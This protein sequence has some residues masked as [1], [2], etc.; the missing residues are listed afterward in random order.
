MLPSDVAMNTILIFGFRFI[1]P[2]S[3]QIV[4]FFST[5][6]LLSS[7]AI[8]NRYGVTTECINLLSPSIDSPLTRA[9]TSVWYTDLH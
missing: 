2:K 8:S 5:K 6:S 3:V 4:F 9:L 7:L 1:V